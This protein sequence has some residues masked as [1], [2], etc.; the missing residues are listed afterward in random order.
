MYCEI[1]IGGPH[2]R[3]LLMELGRD[4]HEYIHNEGETM[5][6][7]RSTYVY[8]D[9]AVEYVKA[10]GTLKNFF[11]SRSID[12]VPID[13]DRK[14]NSD[15]HT[16]DIARSIVMD[17]VDMGAPEEA[18]MPMF[19]G[20]GYHIIVDAG[21][22]TFPAKSKDLPF[23]V[24]RT[25]LGIWDDLD[26]SIYSRTGI[27]RLEHT[28]NQKSSLYKIPLTHSE[29]NN[30]AAES[31]KEYAR[32]RFTN[33]EMNHLDIIGEGNGELKSHVTTNIPSVRA[34]TNVTEPR[35]VVPCVQEMYS[36]GPEHGQRN[37]YILRIAS[38][39]R[40]NGIH[41][42]ATKA[43]LLWWNKNSMKEEIVLDKVE[44]VY[45]RGYK[46]SCH[47]PLM[48]KHCKPRCIYYKHKDYLVETYSARDM[49][50]ELEYRLTADFTGRKID[51]AKLFGLGNVDTVIY[52][53][54]LVT[55]CGP[56]GSN[57]TTL[58]QNIALAYH[59][60]ED[61]IA[62]DEQISTLYL[63]L[64]LSSWMMHRRNLQILTGQ[65]KEQIDRN[66]KEMFKFHKNEL[67][68]IV[69]QTVAP[70]INQIADKIRELQPACVIVDYIDLVEPPKGMRGEYETIR[71]I[72]HQLSS[73]AVNLDI[74]I[75][76][77]SQT[78]REYSRTEI[79]DLYSGKGSGAI[80]NASRKV[81]ILQGNAKSPYKTIKLLKNSDGDLWEIDLK[82]QPSFRMRRT[83]DGDNA[84]DS[85]A[86]T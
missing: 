3:G 60:L 80:E 67:D 4:I 58:A 54:E 7:Y 52:P 28:L 71:Y 59:A 24:K 79:L 84:G 57:K 73:L 53:G 51:L 14:D 49:Q 5:P 45:N 74:I 13:I 19:S 16:L 10:N 34:F 85:Q 32:T 76:Q 81:M 48:E 41:S 77:I 69:V 27:Y 55:I 66:V 39:F 2:N 68:H 31:I 26:A 29:L 21:I 43:A 75:I 78:S 61:V 9:E 47:D 8:D 82:W 11:G 86:V 65:S 23:I 62:K 83:Y 1:A 18:I 22:F 35:N 36:Q 46:Y 56:T 6:I 63:S 72:C 30:M 38:H 70:T 50:E 42:D 15:E 40:R 12:V 33:L 25:I 64:E 17:L 20:T 37:D 44:S